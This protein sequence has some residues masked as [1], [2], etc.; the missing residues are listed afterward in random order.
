[1]G[2]VGADLPVETLER[3]FL[4]LDRHELVLGPTHDGGCYLIGLRGW[5]DV[6]RD[7]PMSTG[8]ELE[9]IL[10]LAKRASLSAALLDPTFDVDVE[11]DLGHLRDELTGRDALDA[12]RKAFADLGLL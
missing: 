9:G 7:V 11:E 4:K 10:A 5:H 1:M 12:T 6:L 2:L 8:S 3:A